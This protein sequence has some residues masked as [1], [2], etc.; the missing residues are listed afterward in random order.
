MYSVITLNAISSVAR[1]SGA[2]KDFA[3]RGAEKGRGQPPGR[4]GGGHWAVGRKS[5]EC[6]SKGHVSEPS[7]D[8]WRR[9]QRGRA[10]VS[11]GDRAEPDCGLRCGSYHSQ[12]RT[13]C[14]KCTSNFLPTIARCKPQSASSLG[15]AACHHRHSSALVFRL[16]PLPPVL[17]VRWPWPWLC[18]IR[19]RGRCCCCSWRRS[20][21]SPAR[22]SPLTPPLPLKNPLAPGRTWPRISST[23]S[24]SK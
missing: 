5:E 18:A 24:P 11:K 22:G 13:G 4:C 7:L 10:L 2:L 15:S 6:K 19:A 8:R 21:S 20:W 16:F 9:G 23:S 17:V 12:S 1:P 14:F 3:K